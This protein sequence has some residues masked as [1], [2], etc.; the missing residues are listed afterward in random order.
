M[1]RF[2]DDRIDVVMEGTVRQPKSFVW[3]GRNFQVVEILHAWSDWG[4]S[5]AATRRNWRTRKH[6]NYYRIRTEDE[7]IF[8][9]YLDRGTKPGRES[10]YVFQEFSPDSEH[11]DAPA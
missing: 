7:R 2:I 11:D 8:E 5:L 1:S 10:W 4:F 3:Q 6:R 9:I